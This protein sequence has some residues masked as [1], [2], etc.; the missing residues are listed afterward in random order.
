MIW[1]RLMIFRIRYSKKC[2]KSIQTDKAKH[3][4]KKRRRRRTKHIKLK[5][6]IR[7]WMLSR[8]RSYMILTVSLRKAGLKKQMMLQEKEYRR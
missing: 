3:K 2:S 4:I 1:P 5:I 8:T 7:N 6:K